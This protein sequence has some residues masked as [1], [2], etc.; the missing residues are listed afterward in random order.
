VLASDPNNSKARFNRGASRIWTADVA[1]ALDDYRALAM[2]EPDNLEA[3][4]MRALLELAG[5]DRAAAATEANYLVQ[6]NPSA[7]TWLLAGEAALYNG[8]ADD[9]KTFYQKAAAADPQL[10]AS[11]YAQGNSLQGARVYSLAYLNFLSALW[12]KPEGYGSYYAMGTCAMQM[13]W[14]DQAIDAYQNYLKYDSTST[15][16]QSARQQIQTLRQ[17]K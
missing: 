1:G 6:K 3:R 14:K 12:L 9:A 13:G 16:A 2:S 5:G 7:L 4:R 11:L 15:F 10:S 17:A 8:R